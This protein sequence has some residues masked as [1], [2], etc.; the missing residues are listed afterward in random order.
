VCVCGAATLD[1]RVKINILND[2]ILLMCSTNLKLLI[3][4][5]AH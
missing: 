3:Q 2:N 1:G 5:K 4:I